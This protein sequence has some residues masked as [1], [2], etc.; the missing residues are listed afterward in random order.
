M[1]S[2]AKGPSTGPKMNFGKPTF[3][4]KQ[5]GIMDQQDFPELGDAATGGAQ[6]AAAAGSGESKAN[7]AIQFFGGAAAKGARPAGEG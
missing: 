5:K 6:G 1:A 3:S 2:A 7:S 4:R